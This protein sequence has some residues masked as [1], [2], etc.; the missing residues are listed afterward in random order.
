L[1]GK[2]IRKHSETAAAYHDESTRAKCASALQHSSD[3]AATHYR[4]G[5]SEVAIDQR[6]A[7]FNVMMSDRM[8]CSAFEDPSKLLNIDMD[9]IPF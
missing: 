1:S 8:T 2:M 3:M 5:T 7:Q 9:F 4:V 6:E